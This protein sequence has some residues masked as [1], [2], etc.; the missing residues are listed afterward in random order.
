MISWLSIN[1]NFWL[2]IIWHK[3][4]QTY[5]NVSLVETKTL[6]S[7]P[8]SDQCWSLHSGSSMLTSFHN[9]YII[10]GKN[11]QMNNQNLIKTFIIISLITTWIPSMLFLIFGGFMIWCKLSTALCGADTDTSSRTAHKIQQ[12]AEMRRTN[13][14]ITIYQPKTNLIIGYTLQRAHFSEIYKTI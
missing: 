8:F 1:L 6:C 12:R 2:Y 7:L 3:C 9:R 4:P 13:F 14:T 10:Y 11:E 5:R